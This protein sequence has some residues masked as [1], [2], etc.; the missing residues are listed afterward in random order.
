MAVPIIVYSHQE[1]DKEIES[2]AAMVVRG[3]TN[4]W[5]RSETNTKAGKDHHEPGK[6]KYRAEK[7]SLYVVW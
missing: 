7:I 6:N 2:H 4:M 1:R 3:Y 5:F